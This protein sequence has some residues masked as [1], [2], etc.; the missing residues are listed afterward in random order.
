[1]ICGEEGLAAPIPCAPKVHTESSYG[2]RLIFIK[3]SARL[4]TEFPTFKC[5]NKKDA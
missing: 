2:Y 5:F 1:M 3:A 4:E